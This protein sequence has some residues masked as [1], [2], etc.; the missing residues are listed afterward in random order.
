[1]IWYILTNLRIKMNFAR[2][3]SQGRIWTKFFGVVILLNQY[4]RLPKTFANI[5]QSPLFKWTPNPERARIFSQKWKYG[6]TCILREIRSIFAIV[7]K[8]TALK[9][10]VLH[11]FFYVLAPEGIKEVNTPLI[12]VTKPFTLW[13]IRAWEIWCNPR[14]SIISLQ[15]ACKS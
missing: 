7:H 3:R 5:H 11:N 13:Q 6:P 15:Y 12:G 8:M 1:M 14:S 9:I 2:K 4:V 10:W